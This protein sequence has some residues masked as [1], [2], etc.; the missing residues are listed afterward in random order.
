M[1]QR[2]FGNTGLSI[3]EVGLGTW[4]LGGDFGEM[5]EDRA[6]DILKLAVDQGV[7]FFDTADVYGGGRSESLIGKFLKESKKDI[8]V[9]TKFGR[10]GSVYPDNYSRQAMEKCLT[11]SLERLQKDTLDLVQLHCIPQ[12]ELEKGDVFEDLRYFQQKGMI[13]HWG[14]SVETMGEAAICLDQQGI[15]NLQVIFNIFRQNPMDEILPRAEKKGVGVLV[16]LPLASGMLAGKYK[17]DTQFSESDHRNYNANGDAF[18]VGET[19]SGI[20]FA[21]GLKLVEKIRPLVPEGMSMAQ[22][23]QRWVLDH[24][25][26]STIITGST[27]TYQVQDNAAVSELPSLD[28]SV[29]KELK[30]LYSAEIH[31]LIRGRF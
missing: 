9:A 22:F 29:H 5:P 24:S 19:F 16:R 18:S 8:F 17:A 28:A 3:S 2:I 7:S 23:A 21:K 1:K 12:Q 27:K 10:D 13:K 25:A 14:A 15:T 26:V 6:M 20:E 11:A 4:Q 31:Q 30:E